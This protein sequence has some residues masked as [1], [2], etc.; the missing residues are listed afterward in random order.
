[1]TEI[2]I[3]TIFTYLLCCFAVTGHVFAQNSSGQGNSAKRVEAAPNI[4]VLLVDDLGW[5]DV[6]CYGSTFYETPNIDKLAQSGLRFT[7]AYASCNVCSPS[8]AS[9]L[10]GKNPARLHL[11]DWIQGHEK[12]Y[13]KL[14]PPHWTQ[15]LPLEE[16]TIAEVLKKKNYAT[17]LIG[18][19]H[20]GDDIKYYPENQ[21]FDLNIGG[22]Y[23]GSPP[24]YFSP[25]RIPRL[26]DG[27]KGEYLTDRL[28][29]DAL[30]F[31]REKKD[32][33]FF[34]YL[35]YYAVHIPLQGK[36]DDVAYF[37]AKRD[38]TANQKN[39]IYAAVIKSVDESVG[40]VTQL[41][42]A[43]HLAKNTIIIFM[44]DNGGI[45]GMKNRITSN[46]PLRGGKGTSYEGGVRVPF[47]VRWEGKIKSNTV[48]D[49]PIIHA[50]FFPTVA[51]ITASDVSSISGID[52]VSITPLLFGGKTINRDALFWHYPHYHTE[53]A[54]PFSS[55][56]QG[57]WKLIYF[58]ETAKME[59][60]NL[61][62]DPGELN[63][64]AGKE[65][66]IVTMLFEKIK[67]WKQK[68]GAQDPV[69]NPDYN[70]LKVNEGRNPERVV[71][72]SLSD[73]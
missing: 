28:T 8:R 60:Y 65:T 18:K 31:I 53:G 44:S 9:I 38:S 68:V 42:E 12:P 21:G 19:W 48:C 23:L 26:K 45:L 3:K 10:T 64:V 37:K 29:E 17:A 56:R 6:R 61:R 30:Q 15:F 11:T 40:K 22:N 35:S 4:I 39:A 25:Y 69:S 5:T 2:L 36:P 46:L 34:L 55:I 58:Y 41:V 20:L 32:Q 24:S 27:P 52:G 71:V 33:P 13:A 49:I 72:D 51:E 14:L 50:D 73:E 7:N 1:M 66:K 54:T 70:P 47:I 57:D 16:T 62:N 43:L 59:L 67:K 63:D